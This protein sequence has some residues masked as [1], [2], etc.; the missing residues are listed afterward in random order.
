MRLISVSAVQT[1]GS[2]QEPENSRCRWYRL[3]EQSNNGKRCADP[4]V[5]QERY[6]AGS[7]CHF[8]LSNHSKNN[9]GLLHV[10][11]IFPLRVGS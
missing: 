1:M 4:A 9:L 6:H 11:E 8:R 5:I 10:G 2:V 3:G 7:Q